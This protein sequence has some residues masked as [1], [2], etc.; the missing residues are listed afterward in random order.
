MSDA[1]P[2]RV[3]FCHFSSDVGG[4]SDRSLWDLVSHLDR[5]AVSPA[6]LLRRGDPMAQRYRDLG[7]PVHA[8]RLVSPRRAFAPVQLARYAISFAPSTLALARAIR[9]F[10]ADVVHVNTLH[11]LQGAVAARVAGRPLV[12]HVRE[13]PGDSRAGRAMLGLVPRLA[14]H[15]VAISR[16]VAE[17]VGGGPELVRNVANGIDIDR[18]AA[19]P[20]PVDS[21]GISRE[22]PVVLCVGRMEYW[23]GQHVLLEAFPTIAKSFPDVR[24]VFVGG[25]ARNKPEYLGRLRRRARELSVDGAIV[26]AGVREDL[27]QVMAASTVLVLPTCTAEPFGRTVVEAM[28]A[29]LP[30]VATDAGGPREI[31]LPGE[32]GFLVP[33]GDADALAERVCWLLAHPDAARALGARGRD[34]AERLYALPRVVEEMTAVFREAAKGRP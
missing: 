34:R 25:P 20:D 7:L 19:P 3:A 31:I 15:A 12:W 2:V 27:P 4:G 13:L 22:N 33:P 26:F 30:V 28:A 17:A 23:K 29:G 8:F 18:F 21:L 24:L 16:A 32:T 1:N 9:R 5:R 10:R 6:M 14:T 11:N